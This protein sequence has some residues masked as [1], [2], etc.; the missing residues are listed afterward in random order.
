MNIQTRTP[1]PNGATA[2]DSKQH[3]TDNLC[4]KVGLVRKHLDD[5]ERA[6]RSD[7]AE[8]AFLHTAFAESICDELKTILRNRMT[9][10]ENA[11]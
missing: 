1:S 9:A 4:R 5:A 11:K 7:Q 8:P 3:D 10:V 6:I 2:E